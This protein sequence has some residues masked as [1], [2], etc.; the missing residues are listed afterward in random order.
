MLETNKKKLF[1]FAVLGGTLVMFK[2]S[3]KKLF[4]YNSSNIV[5]T[6]IKN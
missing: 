5:V 6:Y 1:K 2:T 3:Y 4:E